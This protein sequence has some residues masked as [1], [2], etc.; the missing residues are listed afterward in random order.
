MHAPFLL[1]GLD[2]LS[3]CFPGMN[4]VIRAFDPYKYR[5]H[6]YR[7]GMSDEEFSQACLDQ[8]CHPGSALV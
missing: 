3:A 7:E 8:V 1:F 2:A 5:S 6:L 4:G